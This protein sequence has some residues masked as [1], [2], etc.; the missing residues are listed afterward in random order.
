[1]P[2]PFSALGY[3]KICLSDIRGWERPLYAAPPS[4]SKI[5][6]IGK[7]IDRT[8]AAWHNTHYGTAAE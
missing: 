4:I 1:V 8:G 2:N 7:S 3:L 6:P 5:S